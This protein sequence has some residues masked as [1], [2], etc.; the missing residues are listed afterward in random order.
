MMLLAV[1]HQTIYRYDQPMRHVTQSHR[2]QPSRFD[3]QSVIDWE[4]V[5][6]GGR[7][8]AS[9]VDGA[10]D[11]LSTLSMA[12]PLSELA[13][14]VRGRVETS[15][16]AGVLK[17]HRESIHPFAYLRHTTATRADAALRQLANE[18][19][20]ET[21]IRDPLD[22]AHRLSAAVADTIDYQP[23][24]THSHTTAAQALAE[25]RGVC[26]DHAHALIAMAVQAGLPARYVIGYL[27]S[28]ADGAAHE[29]SHAWAEVHVAGLGW[30]G[31]DVSN[32]CCPDERY[33]RLGSGL[34]ALQAAPIRGVSRGAGSEALDVQVAINAIGQDQQ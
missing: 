32:R 5:V 29:A 19:L 25:G 23:G 7:F 20:G 9:F 30:V 17:G 13:V 15:D 26:Q 31:F 10:G 18:A 2:L 11:R 22:A 27:H 4:V 6:E 14:V 3:G 1:D 8:G 24:V 34:D 16:T 21:G 33:I 28:G 12:G